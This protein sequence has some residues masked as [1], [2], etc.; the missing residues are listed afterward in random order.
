MDTSRLNHIAGLIARK[1]SGG[2]LTGTEQQEL[3]EWI[4][5]SRMN[6]E[7]YDRI[8]SGRGVIR[9]MELE[10]QIDTDRSFKKLTVRLKWRCWKRRIL[11]AGVAAMVMIGIMS[12]FWWWEQEGIT[13]PESAGQPGIKPGGNCAVLV[14]GN[15]CR[16]DL[17]KDCDTLQL[18]GISWDHR[19][20]TIVYDGRENKTGWPEKNT[21]MVPLRGEYRLVLGDGTKVWLNSA[22]SLNYP[23]QFAE[24]E[25]CVELDGE[26]YFEVTPDPERPFIVKS[27]GVQTRVLGTAFNFS[28]Y[29]GENASTITLLTGKVAVSAPGHAERVLLPGQ[30]LKYDAENRKTVIK[31]VDAEDFVVWKDGLFLFNDCGLEEIIPRLSRWY[32]VT[33]H[34]DREKFGDLK[35][36]IK[37]RRYEDIG[38]ILNLLKLTENVTYSIEGNEVTLYRTGEKKYHGVRQH[39]LFYTNKQPFSGYLLTLITK[40]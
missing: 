10:K 13:V 2:K 28:A 40:L 12:A 39:S 34:Y 26:A 17:Q 38:T 18:P 16:V 1:G 22:S 4:R 5:A 31:E 23:V 15:G 11:T 14:L 19:K 25:R 21:L 29:R 32:G 36:Y 7:S 27:G 20:G 37:T 8:I 35:F 6:R 33:F 9:L 24:K 30:Q 3:E